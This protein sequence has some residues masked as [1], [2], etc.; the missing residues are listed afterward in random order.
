VLR[1]FVNEDG[2]LAKAKARLVACG[3]SNVEGQGYTEVFAAPLK[4]ANF[5]LFCCLIA[6]W[7]WDT[8][9]MDAVKAFIQSDVDTEMYVEMSEGF[10]VSAYVLKLRKALEGIK[11][12]A[13]LWFNKNRQQ[14]PCRL[15]CREL[16]TPGRP[17][18]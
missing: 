8:D 4:A 3:Y 11:Q 16:V 10:S 7:D 12:G 14:A 2:T 18:I 5:R 1:Y 15:R 6:M 13:H 17:S 9:Q